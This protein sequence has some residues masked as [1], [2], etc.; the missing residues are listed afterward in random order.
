MKTRFFT[1]ILLLFSGIWSVH[2]QKT[3]TF[4]PLEL[5]NY[6]AD[7]TDSLYQLGEQWG[8]EFNKAYEASDYS[9]LV[10]KHKQM[11]AFVERKQ[12]EVMAQKDIAGSE[13]L[14]LSVLDFL[15]YEKRLMTE[16]FQPFEQLKPGAS[17]EQVKACISK[18]QELAESEAE[19]LNKVQSAQKAFADKNGFTIEEE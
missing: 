3:K 10:K 11:L 2:A 8:N 12:K 1:L 14:R 4:T 19:E 17:E 5:N 6:Y 16:G 13:N 18:L 15:S 9:A 7:I